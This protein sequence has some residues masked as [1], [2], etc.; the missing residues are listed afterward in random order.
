MEIQ[1]FRAERVLLIKPK[2]MSP[3][4]LLSGAPTQ[5]Q[6]V[7][8]LTHKSQPQ[9]FFEWTSVPDWGAPRLGGFGGRTPNYGTPTSGPAI[10]QLGCLSY[11]FPRAAGKAT[12]QRRRRR[13]N[14]HLYLLDKCVGWMHIFLYKRSQNP[15]L[16]VSECTVATL[17]LSPW[18][19]MPGRGSQRNS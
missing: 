4:G 5:G 18:D 17:D 8:D 14:I 19:S 13:R 15:G 2:F 6:T 10:K 11:S 12:E 1:F 3:A 7:L 9:N 16:L